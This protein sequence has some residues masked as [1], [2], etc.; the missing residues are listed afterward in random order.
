MQLSRSAHRWLRLIVSLTI[1][2]AIGLGVAVVTAEIDVSVATGWA[3]FAFTYCAST[4]VVLGRLDAA[5]TRHRAVQEDPGRGVADLI[6]IVASVASVAGM[7]FVLM[8]GTGPSLLRAGIGVACVLASWMLVHTIYG[9]RY[10]DLYYLAPRP[11][12]DF[13]DDEPRYSDFAYLT[14]C[15]GMTYQISDTSLRTTAVRTTVLWHTLLSYFLG[16][17]VLA[18]TVN[19]VSGLASS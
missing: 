16:A 13:G 18:C 8:A 14:F 5:Q 17:V 3:V 4:W 6:L 7:G 15:L 19:L 11:P 1:G 12:I 2:I 9:M 10:A